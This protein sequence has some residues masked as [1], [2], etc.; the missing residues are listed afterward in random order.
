MRLEL[1]GVSLRFDERE[2]LFED[3]DLCVDPGDF[4]VIEGPSGGGKSSLL[5]L[6]NRLQEPTAGELRVDGGTPPETP[7]LRRRVGLVAQTPLAVPAPVREHLLSPFHFRVHRDSRAPDD[8][9]L[10]HLLDSLLLQQVDLGDGVAPLSVGQRQRL[11][12]ARALLTEPEML[13]CDE[14][15]AALDGDAR[16]RVESRLG[17]CCRAGVGVVLV[18]H[19]SVDVREG[20]RLRRLRLQDRRLRESRP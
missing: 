12:L 18:S 16:R 6:L 11:A 4:V 9:R 20:L 14:P 13:L 5:R 2:P 3:V 15:T 10:R 1:R 7:E 17:E 8:D 19:Q